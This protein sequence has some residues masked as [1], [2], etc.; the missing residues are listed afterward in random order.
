MQIE[1]QLNAIDMTFGNKRKEMNAVSYS[2]DT[3]P[4]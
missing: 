2:Y 3:N 1:A 4:K